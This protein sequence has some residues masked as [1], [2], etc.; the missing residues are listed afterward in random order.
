MREHHAAAGWELAQPCADALP[1][2]LVIKFTE[3][4]WARNAYGGENVVFTHSWGQ[5][6]SCGPV[7]PLG[8][9]KHSHLPCPASNHAQRNNSLSG[10]LL[11][12][13]TSRPPPEITSRALLGG[14]LHPK[15]Q[16]IR[17]RSYTSCRAKQGWSVGQPINTAV[18]TRG[19]KPCVRAFVPHQVCKIA[20]FTPTWWETKAEHFTQLRWS[21][22]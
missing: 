12:I 6:R 21:S 5:Y 18:T 10:L 8:F 13:H 4:V 3:L 11:N 14:P 20:F 15:T 7:H 22:R 2:L 9:S 17:K 19:A 1:D 16:M